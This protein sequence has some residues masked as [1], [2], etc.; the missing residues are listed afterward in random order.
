MT[1]RNCTVVT[2]TIRSVRPRRR[3]FSWSLGIRRR[4]SIGSSILPTDEV[5]QHAEPEILALFRMELGGEDIV[6]PHGRRH[7]TA[8]IALRFH[9]PR[10]IAAEIVRVDEVEIG[11]RRHIGKQWT[12]GPVVHVVPANLGH[13][14]RRILR[15]KADDVGLEPAKPLMLAPLEAAAAEHL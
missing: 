6:L 4:L 9:I 7:R 12:A 3:A 8:I 14:Q 11:M 2:S 15:L 13:P 10:I 1:S 5:V